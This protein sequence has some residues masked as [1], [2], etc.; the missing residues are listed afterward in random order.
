MPIHIF[1]Y[2]GVAVFFFSAVWIS[3]FIQRKRQRK[4]AAKALVRAVANYEAEKNFRQ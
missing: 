2:Y 1:F 4:Q 3:R